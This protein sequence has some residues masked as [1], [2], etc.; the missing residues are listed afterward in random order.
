MV[1]A[2]PRPTGEPRKVFLLAL[3]AFISAR[4]PATILNDRIVGSCAESQVLAV[5]H[6]S[7]K[8]RK[9]ERDVGRNGLSGLFTS[10]LL[11]IIYGVNLRSCDQSLYRKC[12]NIDYLK[13]GYLYFGLW[14]FDRANKGEC[15]GEKTNIS[16]DNHEF[17]NVYSEKYQMFFCVRITLCCE[18]KAKL[19]MRN[20]VSINHAFTRRSCLVRHEQYM[21][22]TNWYLYQRDTMLQLV[23]TLPHA[24]CFY[25]N[26]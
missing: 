20:I 15:C 25:Q 12:T 10:V 11:G 19:T 1:A 5:W 14:F 22:V 26:C 13:R 3:V 24:S 21:V 7:V 4:L 2:F 16:I 23:S 17:A 9:V 18:K 6:L 8:G